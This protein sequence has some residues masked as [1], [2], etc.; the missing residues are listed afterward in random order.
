MEVTVKTDDNNEIKNILQSG[1]MCAMLWTFKEDILR[2]YRKYGFGSRF[3]DEELAE[4]VVDFIESEFYKLLDE[5]GINLD[6]EY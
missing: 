6:D 2:K 3:K 4:E 5:Y 1:R